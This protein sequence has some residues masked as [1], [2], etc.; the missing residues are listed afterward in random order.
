MELNENIK[1]KGDG[2]EMEKINKKHEIGIDALYNSIVINKKNTLITFYYN[3]NDIEYIDFVQDS[4]FGKFECRVLREA[5]SFS[6]YIKYNECYYKI[7]VYEAK[8]LFGKIISFII[9]NK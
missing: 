5:E 8:C 6:G 9:E 7:E 4:C 3:V 2:N 1:L